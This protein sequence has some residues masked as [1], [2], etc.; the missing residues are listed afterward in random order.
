MQS[1]DKRHIEFIN[2]V[3]WTY[4]KTMPEWP[5]EYIVKK[6]V[7]VELFI[8]IVKH[9]RKFGYEGMFYQKTITYFDFEGMVYWTMG[10]PVEETTI[11][12]RCKS[13]NTYEARLKKGTLPKHN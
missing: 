10:A 13:E 7:D 2:S 6:N 4:A 12:N 5:H 8:E 9:I 1:F 3:S 11:I